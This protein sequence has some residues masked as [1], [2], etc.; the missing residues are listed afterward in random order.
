MSLVL[1]ALRRVEKATARPGS[2]GVAVSSYRRTERHKSL[3]APLVLGLVTGA[4]LLYFWRAEPRTRGGGAGGEDLSNRAPSR[5]MAVAP[6][7]ANGT[8]RPLESAAAGSM[9]EKEPVLPEVEEP[10]PVVSGLRPSHPRKPPPV[11]PS[12][13]SVRPA[14]V[15]QAISERDSRPIA[16][17]N[18]QLVREGDVLEGVR[19]LR[20][21]AESVE[22]LLATGT[23]GTI[24]F[25]PP[26]PPAPP[27]SLPSPL[28]EPSPPSS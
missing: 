23:N 20:I 24:R 5:S 15:L 17:I 22:V 6:G 8:P 13:S 10:A 3:G 14:L 2:V 9:P 18:D 21:G 27:P 16:V 19:I 28:G 4:L 26:P 25:A 12:P 11:T 1:E 7:S